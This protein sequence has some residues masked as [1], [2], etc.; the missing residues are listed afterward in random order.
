M[1]TALER[2]LNR[3]DDYTRVE[4]IYTRSYVRS[5]QSIA[6]G[7]RSRMLKST[8][9][10]MLLNQFY[11]VFYTHDRR[12]YE[13]YIYFVNDKIYIY[14]RNIEVVREAINALWRSYDVQHIWTEPAYLTPLSLV[15]TLLNK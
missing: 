10:K 7:D 15:A 8:F 12:Y 11:G 2:I 3:R 14:N 1:S 13:P 4:R 5:E 9:Q 6:R